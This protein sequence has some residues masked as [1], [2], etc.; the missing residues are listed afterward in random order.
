MK[1]P[2]KKGQY[3][4]K[5]TPEAHAKYAAMDALKFER[6]TFNAWWNGKEFY[7]PMHGLIRPQ[8]EEVE[9]WKEVIRG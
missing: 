5:L 7:A 1:A 3:N 6:H 4:L 9:K 8:L 2:T